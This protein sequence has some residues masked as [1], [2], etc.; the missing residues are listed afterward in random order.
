MCIYR[1][2]CRIRVHVC[3]CMDAAIHPHFL[4]LYEHVKSHGTCIHVK[5]VGPITAPSLRAN[6]V[7]TPALT[8]VDFLH[9]RLNSSLFCP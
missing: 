4:T 2:T 8:I 9:L 3:S 7:L 6:H 1:L 5:R